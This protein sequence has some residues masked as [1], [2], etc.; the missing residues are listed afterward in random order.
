LVRMN[1]TALRSG[2]D[3]PL[4]GR[5]DDV[6]HGYSRP[7]TDIT[8]CLRGPQGLARRAQGAGLAHESGR[9]QQSLDAALRERREDR[10]EPKE[11]RTGAERRHQF[12]QRRLFI[13]LLDFV[14]NR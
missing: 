6:V 14:S 10:V 2:E 13:A 1:E 7:A 11:C 12:A 9:D 8:G 5:R 3:R 4:D